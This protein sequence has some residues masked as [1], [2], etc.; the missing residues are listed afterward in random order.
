MGRSMSP[1]RRERAGA[2]VLWLFQRLWHEQSAQDVIEY[3]LLTA[4][5]G[6]AGLA[7][8]GA[9]EDALGA[10]YTGFDTNT[11]GL[12]EPPPPQAPAP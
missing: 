12:W 4:F 1:L 2:R 9:I 7:A 6:L 11:Q 5:I 8:W 10:A 3:A